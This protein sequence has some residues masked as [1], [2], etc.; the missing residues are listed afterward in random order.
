MSFVKVQQVKQR[1]TSVSAMTVF[2]RNEG[3]LHVNLS[4]RVNTDIVDGR[5]QGH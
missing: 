3:L 5:F 1:T 4:L 2:S